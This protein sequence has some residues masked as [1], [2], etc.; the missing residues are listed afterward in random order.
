MIPG[1]LPAWTTTGDSDCRS[2]G[3]TGSFEL[4]CEAAV[5]FN[6]TAG[7]GT[8]G[9]GTLANPFPVISLGAGHGLTT[10]WWHLGTTL[11]GSPA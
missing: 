11:S 2:W 1:P 9:W 3:G 10:K 7:S 5:T 8:R 6:A 4:P